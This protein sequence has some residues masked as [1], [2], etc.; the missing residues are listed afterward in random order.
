MP[1]CNE[2]CPDGGWLELNSAPGA[3]MAAITTSFDPPELQAVAPGA[4]WTSDPFKQT[5]VR[6]YSPAL[7]FR[8]TAFNAG[9]ASAGRPR[10]P[11]IARVIPNAFVRTW[12]SKQMNPVRTGDFGRR[13]AA[14]PS[15][16]NAEC[17]MLTLGF[18]ANDPRVATMAQQIPPREYRRGFTWCAGRHRRRRSRIGRT[19]LAQGRLAMKPDRR[20]FQLVPR[21][22][23]LKVRQ[24]GEMFQHCWHNT[25]TA[26]TPG[27]FA[28]DL[29]EKNLRSC[30]ERENAVGF[31]TLMAYTTAF[32][33]RHGECCLLGGDT[34]IAP[35]A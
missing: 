19:D 23:Y 33:A 16:P 15:Q 9:R 21:D 2:V 17:E 22:R 35:E 32:E 1:A 14:H 12:S 18:A 7:A 29:A 30:S 20:Q 24:K 8:T 5:V 13:T 4:L 10:L 31:S 26:V 27:Q 28:R 34:S 3:P 11:P 25:S 6:G